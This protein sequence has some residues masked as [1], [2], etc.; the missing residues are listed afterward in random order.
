MRNTLLIFDEAHFCL[1]E[2]GSGMGNIGPYFFHEMV[3]AERYT[4]LLDKFLVPELRRQRKLSSTFF[5]QDGATCH[6][7]KKNDGITATC[8]WCVSH[9]SLRRLQL[10]ASLI[11]FIHMR[12]FSLGVP[13]VAGVCFKATYV[14]CVRE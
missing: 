5:Q 11:Q 1:N 6:M 8:V 14:G 2:S 9:F 4:K 12:L 3:N 13:E 10:A 7:A